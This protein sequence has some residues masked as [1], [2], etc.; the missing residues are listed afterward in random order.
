MTI[1]NL[2]KEMLI[3]RK[4]H[5]NIPIFI[6]EAACPHRCIFCNQQNIT[7]QQKQPSIDDVVTIIDRHLTTIPNGSETEIAFFGGNFTGLSMQLQTDYLQSVQH[8]LHEGKISS[9]RCSTRPDYINNQAVELLISFGVKMVELGAQSFDDEVLKASGRGHSAETV[10]RAAG[11]LKNCKMP[12]G[13]Q[14]MTGLPCDTPEKT[15]QTAKEIVRSGAVNTRIY[16]CLVVKNTLLEQMYRSRR[17]Q[18]QTLEEAVALCAELVVFFERHNVKILRVGLHRSEGF[19]SGTA[20]VA[21]PYHPSFNELVE[22]CLW[23]SELEKHIRPGASENICIQ[24]PKGCSGLASGHRR[25][26][27][28]WLEQYFKTVRFIENDS[29]TQRN[30]HV[31]YC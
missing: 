18:P 4:K 24:V 27:R 30:C 8:F 22:S 6:P 11:I 19:D 10:R 28:K 29:L 31:D 20:L 25:Y 5:C 12:F 9:I 15:W 21:G 17:Y 23:R 2:P 26:N 14:M 1:L 13:L 3:S 16:P 7:A